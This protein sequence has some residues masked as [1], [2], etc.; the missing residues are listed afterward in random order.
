[1]AHIV[2]LGDSIFDNARYVPGEPSVIDHL[3]QMLPTGWRATLLAVDGSESTTM[4]FQLGRIPTEVSNLV[5]SVGGNDA[6]SCSAVIMQEPARSFREVLSRMA[7]IRF[8]FERNY[9][10]VLDQLL[11]RGKPIIVCTVYDAVPGLE[12]AELAG[13][14]LFNDV[15]LREAFRGGLSVIDLRQVCT[16]RR[17]YVASSPIEPSVQG[18]WKIAQAIS[19]AVIE[20]AGQ[21]AR[22]RVF[23]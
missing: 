23:V 19:R 11:L 22:S 15:I 13:L 8:E 6:L 21:P 2:L 7:E 17:D 20:N 4:A 18:G 9:R 1:M 12:T 14:C 10:A 5:L 16:E 3:K